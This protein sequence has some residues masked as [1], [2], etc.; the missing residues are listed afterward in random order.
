[1]AVSQLVG[2][3][4]AVS[5][6]VGTGCSVGTIMSVSQVVGFGCAVG[7]MITLVGVT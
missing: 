6:V 5:Q 7:R 2:K 3:M 1:M 4:V